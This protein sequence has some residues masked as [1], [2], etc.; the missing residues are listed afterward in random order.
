VVSE[1]MGKKKN[2]RFRG[3]I[4]S[5]HHHPCPSAIFKHVITNRSL[6]PGKIT[7]EVHVFKLTQA[8]SITRPRVQIMIF[9]LGHDISPCLSNNL[10][11]S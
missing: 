5:F 9:S 8:K 10:P 6:I 11:L 4:S 1:K 3:L 2:K 7:D